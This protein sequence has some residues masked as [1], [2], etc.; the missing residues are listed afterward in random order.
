MKNIPAR[1]HWTEGIVPLSQ[2]RREAWRQYKEEDNDDGE[3]PGK[4]DDD[5]KAHQRRGADRQALDRGT[6][7]EIH[8]TIL[9]RSLHTLQSLGIVRMLCMRVMHH[10]LRATLNMHF[11][12]PFKLCYWRLVSSIIANSCNYWE[13]ASCASQQHLSHKHMPPRA[14]M[15]HSRLS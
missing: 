4:W 7:P 11:V 6:D 1:S 9:V 5:D 8:R 12:R 10:H 13:S 3:V 2:R 15:A 14:P